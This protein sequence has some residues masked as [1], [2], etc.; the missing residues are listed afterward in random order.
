MFRITFQIQS[1]EYFGIFHHQNEI[2]Y[3]SLELEHKDNLLVGA[4]IS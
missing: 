2:H 4:A 3:I 1:V